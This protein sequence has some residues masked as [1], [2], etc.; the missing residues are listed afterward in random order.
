LVVFFVLSVIFWWGFVIRGVFGGR[1][2]RRRTSS[3]FPIKQ[4]LYSSGCTVPITFFFSGFPKLSAMF[5]VE[6]LQPRLR[7]PASTGSSSFCRIRG[8]R[9]IVSSAYY[10]QISG[11]FLSPLLDAP[12]L[13]SPFPLS[14]SLTHGSFTRPY[15]ALFQKPKPVLINLDPPYK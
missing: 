14:R 4:P 12:H 8:A 5:P 1:V 15:S 7:S 3:H 2:S 10:N 11:L 13:Y 9:F 6:T